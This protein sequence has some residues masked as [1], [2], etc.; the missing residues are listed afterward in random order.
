MDMPIMAAPDPAG[1]A[2]AAK[3]VIFDCDGVLIDS[4]IV[5]CRLASEELT[6][7][8]YPI[9]LDQVIERFAGRPEREMMAEVAG[10]LGHPVPAE[11]YHR[12]RLRIEESYRTELRAVPGVLETLGALRIPACVAS[13]SHPAKLRLGLEATGLHECLGPNVISASLVAHGKPAPDVFIYAAGWMRA[14]VGD[15]VVVEDSVHGVR[16]A[17]SAG[18]HVIGF[19]GGAHCGP[20]H[21]DRL[22]AA[23]A[24]PVVTHFQELRTAVPEA[25]MAGAAD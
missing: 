20:G 17:V 23:G 16:A 15:C 1:R 13:S 14:S 3:L 5:V 8:G 2:A 4:E 19:T 24:S 22:A 10:D 12:L 11:Y 18:M 9:T 25:F 7:I 6:R 21:G